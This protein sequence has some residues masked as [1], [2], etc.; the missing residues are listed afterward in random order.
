MRIIIAISLFHEHVYKCLG[1]IG[2]SGKLWTQSRLFTLNVLKEFGFGRRILQEKILEEVT[3][4]QDKLKKTI[5]ENISSKSAIQTTGLNI[6][7]S[8]VFNRRY[9]DNDPKIKFIIDLIQDQ[10][11]NMEWSGALEFLPVLEYL[12]GDFFRAKEMYSIERKLENFIKEELENHKK[13]FDNRKHRDYI[14]A[15]LSEMQ[16]ESSNSSTWQTGKDSF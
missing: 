16:K 6:M 4:L 8:L 2:A 11:K 5:G 14:D 1:I 15:Y 10:I 12:P 13:T 7:T 9:E 3:H